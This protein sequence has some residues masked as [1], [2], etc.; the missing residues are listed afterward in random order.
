VNEVQLDELIEAYCE[1]CVDGMSYKEMGQM[2]FEMMVDSFSQYSEADMIDTITTVYDEDVLHQLCEGI[3]I[4]PD[5][6]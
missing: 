4:D 3:G 1:M 6:V 2:L 5:T